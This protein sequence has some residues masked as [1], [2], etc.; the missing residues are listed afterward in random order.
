M[1]LRQVTWDLG[2]QCVFVRRECRFSCGNS[3]IPEM[4]QDSLLLVSNACLGDVWLAGSEL[5]GGF[6]V[7][8]PCEAAASCSEHPRR[9]GQWPYAW[10]NSSGHQSVHLRWHEMGGGAT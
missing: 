4:V 1:A 5:F 8:S 9:L 2:T 3:L 7:P 10:H 6:L